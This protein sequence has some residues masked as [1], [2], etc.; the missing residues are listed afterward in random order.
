MIYGA[1]LLFNP[2]ASLRP[3]RTS[4]EA[5]VF[6]ADI[7]IRTQFAKTGSGLAARSLAN[8]LAN[9]PHET[10]VIPD[11]LGTDHVQAKLVAEAPCF[12]VEVEENF[13]VIGDEADGRD[14]DIRHI[15]RFVQLLQRVANIRLQPWLRGRPAAT[16]V[17]E[18]PILI[19]K[20]FTDQAA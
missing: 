20:R 4:R 12:G 11:G 2:V 10:R 8:Q 3:R 7:M 18:L 6:R 15:S 13:Q 14:N 19:R 1:D 16:L 9:H 17:N 5:T